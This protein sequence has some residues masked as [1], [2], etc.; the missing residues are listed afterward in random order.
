MILT[1]DHESYHDMI[2][3][4]DKIGFSGLFPSAPLISH[5]STVTPY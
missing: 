2:Q 5:R 4:K 3:E 1:M